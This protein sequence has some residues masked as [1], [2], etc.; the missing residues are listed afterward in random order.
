MS[1]KVKRVYDPADTGDG[2]R[3]LVDRLWPRGLTKGA[4]RVDLWLRDI[5]PSA[6]LRKWFAHD[7][8][9]WSEFKKRYMMELREKADGIGEIRKH[10]KKGV[11]TLLF[12]ASEERFNNAMV[13]KE[14]LARPRKVKRAEWKAK[15][16]FAQAEPYMGVIHPM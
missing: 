2:F 1:I 13:L 6:G 4:A 9:K 3:I 10:A 12:G 5:A 14:Y 8:K 11:V 16:R 15:G 7:A